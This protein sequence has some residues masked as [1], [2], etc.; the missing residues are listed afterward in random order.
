MA[1]IP[2]LAAGPKPAQQSIPLEN[3][4]K[5]VN[6]GAG[7]DAVVAEFVSSAA[8]ASVAAFAAAAFSSSAFASAVTA[9]ADFAVVLASLVRTGFVPRL[10]VFGSTELSAFFSGTGEG[11]ATWVCC[12]HAPRSAAPARKQMIFFIV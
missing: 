5:V 6:Y 9:S 4:G 7:L 8:F 11:A 12:S 3:P 2:T 10:N 1:S